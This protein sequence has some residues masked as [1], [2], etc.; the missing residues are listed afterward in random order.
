MDPTRKVDLHWTRIWNKS[1][2][3]VRSKES[4]GTCTYE[5]ATQ[6]KMDVLLIKES[7][8]MCKKREEQFLTLR[9]T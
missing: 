6:L 3:Q 1:W 2:N 9:S 4:Q 5:S 7:V 8:L